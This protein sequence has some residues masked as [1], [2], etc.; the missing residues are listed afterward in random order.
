MPLLLELPAAQLEKLQQFRRRFHGSRKRR[1]SMPLNVLITDAAAR[2]G[3][4][5]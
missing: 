5:T 4:A 2:T 1:E 3:F